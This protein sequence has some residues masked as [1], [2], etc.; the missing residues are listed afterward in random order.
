MKAIQYIRILS[1]IFIGLLLLNACSAPTSVPPSTSSADET[2]SASETAAS[3]VSASAAAETETLA[4]ETT[5]EPRT[6]VAAEKSTEKVSQTN[7]CR[8]CRPRLHRIQPR[9][10]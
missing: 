10:F 2:A 7:V 6:S 1:L 4:S 5:T 8:R 9:G 3:E